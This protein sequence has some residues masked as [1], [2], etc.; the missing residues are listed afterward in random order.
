M[1]L[2]TQLFLG[3]VMVFVLM[4][5]IAVIAYTTTGNLLESQRE[6]NLSYEIMA[7]ARFLEK[8]PIDMQTAKRGYQISGNEQYLEPYAKAVA[9]YKAAMPELK[10]LVDDSPAQ[11]RLLEEID[12]LIGRYQKEVIAPQIQQMKNADAENINL[13]KIREDMKKAGGHDIIE[14]LRAKVTAFIDAEEQNL[15]QRLTNT[16]DLA[17]VSL[18]FVIAAT[19]LAIIL[20]IIAMLIISRNIFRLVGG[21]P[22]TISAVADEIAGGNLDVVMQGGVSE[23]TG[24]RRSIGLMLTSLKT[25][26]EQVRRQDWLKT[27]I[28]RLN[29]VVSGDPDAS[30]LAS[31][32]VTEIAEYMEA[33]IGAFYLADESIN[34]SLLG[35]YAY[36]D[37]KNLSNQFRPGEGLV[38]QAALE[39]QQIVLHNVPDDYIRITSGLGDHVP[40]VITVTPFVYENQV[41]GVIELGFIREM[42]DIQAEYLRQAM[43]ILAIAV[44]SAEARDKL[45][46][47]LEEAQV[48]SEELQVQQE[49]LKAANEELEE[50][51]QRLQTSEEQLRVQQEEMEVTNEELEEKNELLERQTHE[52]ERARREIAGKAE[53]LAMASKYKSEFLA[54]MSHEL[55]TPLNSLLLLAQDLA[56][57]R[58][59]N[60][61]D[62]QTES[63]QVIYNGGKDLLNL[64][65]DILDL[66]KV[67]AGRMDIHAGS[68][69]IQDLAEAIRITFG[70][71]A[72]DKGLSLE[73]VLEDTAPQT[74]VT[75]RK[76]LEQIIKNLISNAVKFTE[77]GGVT[78][79]FG[80][81]KAEANLSRSGL[82]PAETIAISVKDTGIG[83]SPQQHAAIFE[84]F[85]QAD[86]GTSRRYGGT[87][88]GL[89]I[90]REFAHLLGGEIRLESELSRGSVFTLYLPVENPGGSKTVSTGDA[91]VAPATP[92]PA[93]MRSA[94]AGAAAA[95][96][97]PQTIKGISDDR[98]SLQ[99]GDKAIL[100]IEDDLAFARVLFD[101]C[102]DRGFK[103][104]HSPT[105][106]AGLELAGTYLPVGILL[107]IRLPGMDGW[108]VLAAL[109]ENTDT[110]HIPVH[111]L[112]VEDPSTKALHNGAIGHVAKPVTREDL[113]SVFGK[114]E[115]ASADSIKHALV[116][117]DDK[118][119]RDSVVKLLESGNVKVDAAATGMEALDA[120]RET[121]YDCVIL[122]IGLPDV[123]GRELLET[124]VHENIELPP[125][126]IHTARDLTPAEEIAVREYAES[127]VIKDV[128]SQERLLDEVSLFLHQMV[129]RMPEHKKQIIQNLHETDTLLKDKTILVV[130]DDMRTT[131][132]LS[133]LLTTRG[134]KTLKAENGERALRLLEEHDD[135]DLVL[136]DIMMPVMDGYEAMRRIRAS[137][138]DMRNIPIIA[139][140][141]KAMK[142]D[143]EHCLEAGANDYMTKPIDPERLVSML[144]VW[145]YR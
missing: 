114:I 95:V 133:R 27:G 93:A 105:G 2:K 137:E 33:H 69:G 96:P 19:L 82:N 62:E 15:K 16:D 71:M 11:L 101:K 37:R 122:D 60:L 8:L 45:G 125:V 10:R 61:S 29:D 91:R 5:V 89:S 111:V 143:R 51:T 66:S 106:E 99:P 103:C 54:N 136:M 36:S 92:K 115:Q 120:L 28:M 138:G 90:S 118:T 107:D 124:L 49:E 21:E 119:V 65:N 116:V 38:G 85:Q 68:V 1:K 108:E 110:R 141:A 76:R 12:T 13:E 75:D 40:R 78:V 22:A 74:M 144:R 67:E 112:S 63:A 30:T 4:I 34:L 127:I 79:T 25:N 46:K 55:R 42:D 129:S 109:K 77:Q 24:I 35:S 84:A 126:I 26:R 31:R 100:V 57:N 43:P 73:V 53:E 104:L 132:A 59:G 52:V 20:G 140:T 139:L 9:S 50:Q 117:E 98:D 130:D 88:L 7:R 17:D 56:S 97:P 128:R 94:D 58:T 121:R 86:G 18:T 41:K 32:T 6:S 135:I 83:I 81:P 134:M 142:E 23:G 80:R 145:L 131:F 48:L 39:Q 44:Q 14:Q 123:D 102:R 87:G 70:R 3:Y 113:E 72:A 47:A 64:I